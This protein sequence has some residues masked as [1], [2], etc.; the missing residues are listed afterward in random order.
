MN[1]CASLPICE[2]LHLKGHCRVLGGRGLALGCHTLGPSLQQRTSSLCPYP[3]HHLM[4]LS[5]LSFTNPLA[6]R[7][8]HHDR[9]VCPTTWWGPAFYPAGTSLLVPLLVH[10]DVRVSNLFLC[11]LSFGGFVKEILPYLKDKDMTFSAKVLCTLLFGSWN[12]L[13]SKSTLWDFLGGS[14]VSA[15]GRGFNPWSGN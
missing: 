5:S 10:L 6:R 4:C 13:L 12:C 3:W 2:Q 9:C 15:G 1:L 14:L 11:G 8:P 7:G